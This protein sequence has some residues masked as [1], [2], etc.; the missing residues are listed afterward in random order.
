MSTLHEKLLSLLIKDKE[1]DETEESDSDSDIEA[2]LDG[3]KPYTYFHE[4]SLPINNTT[5]PEILVQ[6]PGQP[7][8]AELP[9]PERAHKLQHVA[10]FAIQYVDRHHLA[11]VFPLYR[12]TTVVAPTAQSAR[13]STPAKSQD[14]RDTPS[15]QQTAATTGLQAMA[16]SDGHVTIVIDCDEEEN[17]EPPERQPHTAVPADNKETAPVVVGIEAEAATSESTANTLQAKPFLDVLRSGDYLEL[18]IGDRFEIIRFLIDEVLQTTS[19]WYVAAGGPTR[20]PL[21]LARVS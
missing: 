16:N 2:G 3:T 10:L 7:Q 21:T 13:P 19:F 1:E 8:L 14:S 15:K 4:G 17:V 5:W 6:V 11:D 12:Q 9:S 20:L 18:S